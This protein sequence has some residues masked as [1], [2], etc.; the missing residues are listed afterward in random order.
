MNQIQSIVKA[1]GTGK[2]KVNV[3]GSGNLEKSGF[4][5]VFRVDGRLDSIR[6]DRELKKK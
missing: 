2:I 3:Q 6:L 5:G 1:D 4:Q